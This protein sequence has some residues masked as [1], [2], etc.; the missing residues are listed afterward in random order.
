MKIKTPIYLD[1]NSTTQ[2]DP[3]VLET[4]L[5]YLQDRFGNASSNHSFG[6]IAK[7]AVENSRDI[8]SNFLKVSSK[9]I[10]FTSGATES[11]NLVHLGLTENINP[12]SF[13]IITSNLEHSASTESLKHL[14]Q[15]GFDI[16]FINVDNSGIINP[17]KIADAITDKTKLVSLIFAN[18]E[19]GT[20]NDIKT[21]SQICKEHNILFHV[22][23]KQ[24]VGKLKF[25]L[26]EINL[27]FM[28]FTAHKLYGPKGIGALYI[29]S[30]N[31][32]A[33]LV[34]RIFGGTQEGIIKPGTLNVPAIVGFGKAIELCEAEM[35]KDYE[36]TKRLRDSFYKYISSNLEGIIPNG[37]MT[38]RLPNNLNL[39][40]VGVRA[41]KL[42]LEL[43]EL[44]FSNSSA[45]ASG[46]TKPSRILK[47]I[48]LTDEQALCSVRFGFGRFNTK[49]EIDYA[50]LLAKGIRVETISDSAISSLK[51]LRDTAKQHEDNLNNNVSSDKPIYN[52]SYLDNGYIRIFKDFSI[53]PPPLTERRN[54]YYN[55]KIALARQDT[56]TFKIYLNKTNSGA[57]GVLK[58]N[59]DTL[60]TTIATMN[61]EELRSIYR[62]LL[63]KANRV[64]KLNIPP[65][66]PGTDIDSNELITWIEDVLTPNISG[67]FIIYGAKITNNISKESTHI[68]L[69]TIKFKQ[70]LP[71]INLTIDNNF[72]DDNGK[73]I[74]SIK[75]TNKEIEEYHNKLSAA[76]NNINLTEIGDVVTD[77]KNILEILG[78]FAHIEIESK[79]VKDWA[80][81]LAKVND[82]NKSFEGTSIAVYNNNN[83]NELTLYLYSNIKNEKGEDVK[84]ITSISY[85]SS[86]KPLIKN[87]IY[88]STSDD[89]IDTNSF[90]LQPDKLL[91][92]FMNAYLSVDVT[93]NNADKN[94]LL[95]TIT[96]VNGL[97]DEVFVNPLLQIE[98]TQRTK[99]VTPIVVA[100]DN[101]NTPDTTLP[102]ELI[103][104]QG[105]IDLYEEFITEERRKDKSYLISGLRIIIKPYNDVAG[106]VEDIYGLII[107]NKNIRELM[108]KY[109][110]LINNIIN[111]GG[112]IDVAT[113]YD[114]SK[115]KLFVKKDD[116]YYINAKYNENTLNEDIEKLNGLEIDK[117]IQDCK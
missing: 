25:D 48:G 27:D 1:N 90:T 79:D 51:I 36:H 77:R 94:I 58:Y 97:N 11:I 99:T 73:V 69:Y 40:V 55:S 71:S 95:R 33:K 17:T 110:S 50:Y 45:C 8:I 52:L 91:E 22:D 16:T 41:D 96:H 43:R 100:T 78:N 65:I 5:P 66:P 88:L 19:I 109:K 60:D 87:S 101:T 7:S 98:D 75:E 24:A 9:E 2:I 44:A 59:Q 74:R 3:R 105:L 31:P 30:K 93:A 28:S 13:H 115:L 4:M 20:I 18:N 47:A 35:E 56:E 83:T 102:K 81:K 104:I 67:N 92:K 117:K 89:F 86:K 26:A 112:V 12:D 80:K 54:L 29:N 114:I 32:K 23:T 38:E 57:S 108:L 70:L 46:S 106:K 37:S 63:Y 116:I 10:Y 107:A 42:M 82:N 6:W 103:A 49:D 61:E 21:I 84:T 68:P 72:V 113:I 64:L 39:C 76:I 111:E 53:N 85:K 15:K 62:L 34:Q 14:S